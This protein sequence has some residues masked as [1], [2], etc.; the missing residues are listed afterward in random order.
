[1]VAPSRVSLHLDELVAGLLT[2]S[3]GCTTVTFDDAVF[4]L[5]ALKAFRGIALPRLPLPPRPDLPLALAVRVDP[6]A[7]H[8]LGP[9]HHLP[10]L[11]VRL[12]VDT[13]AFGAL[14]TLCADTAVEL[15]VKAFN[16]RCGVYEPVLERTTLVARMTLID[17]LVLTV[18]PRSPDVRAVIT[19]DALARCLHLARMLL[20]APPTPACLA[21]RSSPFRT[22][23]RQQ[24]TSS[25]RRRRP[26]S[27]ATASQSPSPASAC[28]S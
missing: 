6:A 14:S 26:S 4:L 9:E 20:A 10:F 7:F 28:G 27:P 21:E 16:S 18:A 1:M 24:S 8:L 15:S 12:A 19:T 25:R 23:A 3:I 5:N 2:A 11:R 17:R 22:S 13:T